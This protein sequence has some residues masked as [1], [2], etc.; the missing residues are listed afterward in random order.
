MSHKYF[1]QNPN[2][3]IREF[4]AGML[5]GILEGVVRPAPSQPTAP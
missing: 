1:S 3:Q 2:E 5:K 4:L